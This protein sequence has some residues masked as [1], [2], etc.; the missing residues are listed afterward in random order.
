MFF[1]YMSIHACSLILPIQIWWDLVIV[2]LTKYN[3]SFKWLQ[4]KS[5]GIVEVFLLCC[6]AL[7]TTHDLIILTCDI[8]LFMYLF[9]WVTERRI[10]YLSRTAVWAPPGTC[11]WGCWRKSGWFPGRGQCWCSPPTNRWARAGASAPSG[12]ADGKWKSKVM[13]GWD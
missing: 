12:S 13:Q 2:A 8:F 7:Y 6:P 5:C 3:V 1:F 4:P 10:D 9:N 11:R